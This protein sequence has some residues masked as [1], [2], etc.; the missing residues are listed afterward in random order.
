LFGE[1]MAAAVARGDGDGVARLAE[2]VLGRVA[3]VIR[4]RAAG[5]DSPGSDGGAPAVPPG[6]VPGPARL[7]R[8]TRADLD[9]LVG[10]ALAWHGRLSSEAR[11]RVI[12]SDAVGRGVPEEVAA[13]LGK[14]IVAAM[15]R[16]AGE[17][18]RLQ[19]ELWYQ[20]RHP[21]AAGRSLLDVAEQWPGTS[22]PLDEVLPLEERMA[23]FA[24]FAAG[25]GLPEPEALQFGGRLASAIM[26]QD[27]VDAGRLARGVLR[28]LA[29]ETGTTPAPGPAPAGRAAAGPAPG[30]VRGA[31]GDGTADGLGRGGWPS[32]ATLP[33]G[34]CRC[35]WLRTGAATSRTRSGA[36]IR[37]ES[38]G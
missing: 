11:A 35:R 14:R 36:G 3:A 22:A 5:P 4:L 17:L 8:G 16:D 28:R 21:G 13:D 25:R 24:R 31:G 27:R 20:I 6:Q 1:R 19:D 30:R 34:G 26:R 33:G 10:R 38:R 23:P 7:P 18:Q 2:Q 32:P 29:G 9:G 12:A 37:P 15:G